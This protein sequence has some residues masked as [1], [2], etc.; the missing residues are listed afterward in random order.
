MALVGPHGTLWD[1]FEPLH[2]EPWL[3]LS[4]GS[5]MR[6]RWGMGGVV[7]QPMAHPALAA[8]HD[9]CPLFLPHY[10]PST[11]SAFVQCM[12]PDAASPHSHMHGWLKG[13]RAPVGTSHPH[14]G[15]ILSTQRYLAPSQVLW[16]LDITSRTCSQQPSPLQHP[17]QMSSA[18]ST[19]VP[20]SGN[21]LGQN[22]WSPR[23]AYPS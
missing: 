13:T 2:V 7:T 1:L 17:V 16:T 18:T 9:A 12:L 5:L 22:H 14:N 4:A 8:H 3:I 23:G 15:C 6:E 11:C 19:S 21:D 20:H 10:A